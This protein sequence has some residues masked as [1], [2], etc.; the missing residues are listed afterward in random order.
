MDKISIILLAK[1]CVIELLYT[2]EHCDN[3]PIFLSPQSDDGKTG[4]HCN[5]V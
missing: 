3:L 2:R 4:L 5:V 1:K